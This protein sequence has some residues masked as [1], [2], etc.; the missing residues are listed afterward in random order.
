MLHTRHVN[1]DPFILIGVV[2]LASLEAL[3]FA[4]TLFGYPLAGHITWAC[5]RGAKWLSTF[6]TF[7]AP[8]FPASPWAAGI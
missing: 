2:W 1:R 8:V 6:V 5:E 4:S 7:P 3:F